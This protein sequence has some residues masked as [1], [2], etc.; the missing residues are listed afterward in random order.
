MEWWADLMR[1]VMGT[2]NM[3]IYVPQIYLTNSIKRYGTLRSSGGMRLLR[4]V[5]SKFSALI[6]CWAKPCAS[7]QHNSLLLSKARAFYMGEFRNITTSIGTITKK[8][9]CCRPIVR[10]LAQK[11]FFYEVNFFYSLVKVNSSLK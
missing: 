8:P 3:H 1:I 2:L 9:G 5:K 4:K 6:W 10:L 7:S 11:F